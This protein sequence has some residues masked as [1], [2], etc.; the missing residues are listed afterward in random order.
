MDTI[1][2]EIFSISSVHKP[3][4]D[5]KTSS[6]SRDLYVHLHLLVL[7]GN[8]QSYY[9]GPP[10]HFLFQ[11]G[12]LMEDRDVSN[13]SRMAGTDDHKWLVLVGGIWT[14]RLGRD[15]KTTLEN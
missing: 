1:R 10:G 2:S 11:G 5:L 8:A 6:K 12:T 7:H 15:R 4:T 3:G 9:H 14:Q 13:Q